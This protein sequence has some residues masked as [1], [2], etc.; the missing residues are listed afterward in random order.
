M[1]VKFKKGISKIG[2][3][4]CVIIPMQ[5]IKDEHINPEEEYE[6]EVIPINK[7]P[8]KNGRIGIE[9]IRCGAKLTFGDR[10]RNSVYCKKCRDEPIEDFKSGNEVNQ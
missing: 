8:Q 7:E 9:C 3:S 2:D 1:I 10:R 5:Y 6:F 4:Y